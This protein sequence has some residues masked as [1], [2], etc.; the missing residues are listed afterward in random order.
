[1]RIKSYK[2][3]IPLIFFI[4]L[5]CRDTFAPKGECAPVFEQT[6]YEYLNT[7]GERLNKSLQTSIELL[8]K[9]R[10]ADALENLTIAKNEAFILIY[11]DIPITEA[12]QLIYDAGHMHTMG[13]HKEAS[14][15]LS[16]VEFIIDKI[17]QHMNEPVRES[18]RRLYLMTTEIRLLIEEESQI[19]S[20]E[21]LL[22]IAAE[23]STKTNMLGHKVNM[24]ALKSD[25][26]L[27][28][29]R[30]SD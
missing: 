29:A 19:K 12:R 2:A 15:Y 21:E 25:L 9:G 14:I 4:L 22:N 28:G 8:N 26:L 16:R 7:A 30:F 1:M 5:S 6:G 3:L 18:L 20:D 11:F 24:M 27:S 17:M 10:Q 23:I 13:Y